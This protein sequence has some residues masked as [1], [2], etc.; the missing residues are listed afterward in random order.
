MEKRR[1]DSAC[2]AMTNGMKWIADS[3]CHALTNGMKW[4]A[5]SSCHAMTIGMPTR[6]ALQHVQ[7]YNTFIALCSSAQSLCSTPYHMCMHMSVTDALR[8]FLYGDNQK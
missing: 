7:H 1:A 5:D 4:I 3:A 2:H 6:S 8:T